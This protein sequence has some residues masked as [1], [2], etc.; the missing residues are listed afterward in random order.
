MISAAFLITHVRAYRKLC[1]FCR[2]LSIDPALFRASEFIRIQKRSNNPSVEEDGLQGDAPLVFGIFTPLAIRQFQGATTILRILIAVGICIP[3]GVFMGMAFPLEMRI[4]PVLSSSL[5]PWL[6][7][8]N[9]STSVCAS[10][11]ER[12]RQSRLLTWSARTTPEI[13]RPSGIWTSQGLPLT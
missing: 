1:H 12:D 13:A 11:A 3:I 4:A 6:W 2:T 9:G 8:V 5:T 7:G 10:V